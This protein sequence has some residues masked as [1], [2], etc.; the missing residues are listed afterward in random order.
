MCCFAVLRGF[1]FRFGSRQDILVDPVEVLLVR[2]FVFPVESLILAGMQEKLYGMGFTG[3]QTKNIPMHFTLG[4]Y[5]TDREAELKARLT[6][7]A[8]TQEAFPVSFSH[9]GLFRL[10]QNDVL[11]AAP[12][13]TREMLA[14]KDRFMDSSDPFS[15]SPHTT[16]L[17]DKPDV[18]QQAIPAVLDGFSSMDGKVTVLHLY[19]FWPTRHILSVS[20]K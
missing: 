16:L 4:S 8:E 7:I 6:E 11:F 15:W 17:I 18:V 1:L 9:I 19:E 20:L 10:P 12:S 13:V 2:L 5:S 14:L 3:I